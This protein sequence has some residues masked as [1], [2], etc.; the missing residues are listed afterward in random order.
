[1]M[2]VTDEA[3]GFIRRLTDWPGRSADADVC[4]AA[5][6]ASPGR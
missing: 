6:P 5:G 2:S 4:I 1:M 3:I